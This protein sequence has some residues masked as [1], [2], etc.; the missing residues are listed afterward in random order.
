MENAEKVIADLGLSSHPEGGYFRA[1]YPDRRVPDELRTSVV[2]PG[3]ASHIFYCLPKGQHSRLHQL[4]ADEMFHH[5]CGWP[6]ILVE[7]QKDG[8]P[9][10]TTL[11][12]STSHGQIPYHMIPAGTVFGAYLPPGA[13]YSLV[14]C[15]VV[16]AFR[17]ESFR[18]SDKESLLTEYPHCV[19]VISMLS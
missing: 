9:T 16:P 1:V 13:E 5:Y 15:T 18:L 2:E 7:L 6:L 19:D 17:W 8:P 4:G 10:F 3:C 11:G 14:G 12:R